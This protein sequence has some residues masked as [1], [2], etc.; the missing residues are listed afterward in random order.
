MPNPIAQA[1]PGSVVFGGV[2]YIPGPVYPV[3]SGVLTVTPGQGIPVSQGGAGSQPLRTS[4][5][6]PPGA[7]VLVRAVNLTIIAGPPQDF[8][9]SV[10][11]AFALPNWFQVPGSAFS[12]LGE[13]PI[14]EFVDAPGPVFA[15]VSNIDGTT[16]PGATNVGISLN[17]VVFLDCVLYVEASRRGLHG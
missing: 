7:K 1:V 5:D 10:G 3:R 17:C 8:L 14:G 4:R 9:I 11:G 15:D 6:I 12:T 16:I 13:I 2:V